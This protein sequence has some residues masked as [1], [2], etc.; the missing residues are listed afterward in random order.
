MPAAFRATVEEHAAAVRVL[1]A[2]VADRP[3][4]TVPLAEAGGRVT[5]ADLRSPVDLPLFTNSQMDG[6]AIRADEVRGALSGAPVMLPVAAEIAAGPADPA[7]LRPGTAA[8]VMTGAPLPAGADA[9]IPVEDTDGGTE[10]VTIHRYR[11]PG[12]YVRERGSD[13]VAG[14][15][16][17]PA[18]TLLAP[19][20]LAVLAAAGITEAAVRRRIRL[21]VVSTGSELAAPGAALA[22]G[23]LYDANSVTL[24]AA[25]GRA[26]AEIVA[27]SRVRD[28]PAELSALLDRAV[29]AGAEV[30]VTSGGVSMGAYEVVRELLEPRG[31]H[32]G[33]VAMQPGGPQGL[34]AWRGVPVLCF[35]GNPV[36]ALLSFELFL[37]PILRE[38]AGQPPARRRREPLAQDVSSAPGTRQYRRARRTE[39]GI[40]MVGGP[41]SHLVAALAAAELLAIIPEE[42]T[43]LRTGALVETVEL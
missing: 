38:L 12:E 30:I 11:A 33:T 21:A 26:G 5:A 32:V 7:P 4:E 24:P 13:I 20:R 41:G 1:L 43:Q 9:V 42:T 16:L 8:R 28:D 17:I 10:R 19:H 37:A 31:A 22:P 35:P 15:L 40:V 2:P 18:G 3:A 39:Q 6:Y 36:S 23:E 34:A 29:D 25:A 27:V 14:E